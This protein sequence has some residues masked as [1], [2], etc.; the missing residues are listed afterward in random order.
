MSEWVNAW[1]LFL[2]LQSVSS[3]M[4]CVVQSSNLPAAALGGSHNDRYIR[5]K[6]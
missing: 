6:G 2:A 3:Q 5:F 1:I 4:L